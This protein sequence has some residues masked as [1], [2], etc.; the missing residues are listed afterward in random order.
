MMVKMSDQAVSVYPQA[1]PMAQGEVESFLAQPLIAKLCTHNDDGSIHV[2]PIWFKYENGEILLGTQEITQKVKNIQRDNRVSV[3]V[4]T[5]DPTL[6]GVI[7]RGVAELDYDDVIPKRVSIIE[8]YTDP[9]GASALAERLASTWKPVVIH[10]KP[11]QVI[12]FDYSQGF[13]ISRGGE[14]ESMA[15]V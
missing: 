8:K 15:I 3:L 4:D 13:G 10:V 7:V 5:T 9:E 2:V 12:T 6:K 14:A 11:E 1:H